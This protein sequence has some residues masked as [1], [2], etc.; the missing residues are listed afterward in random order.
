MGEPEL[1]FQ[2]L[3]F[4]PGSGALSCIGSAVALM[5]AEQGG[6]CEKTKQ[7]KTGD[8]EGGRLCLSLSLERMMYISLSFSV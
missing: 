8:F 1:A 7:N 4:K 3:I 2:D 6:G 5:K